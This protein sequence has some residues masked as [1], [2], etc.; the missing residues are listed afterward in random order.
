MAR[1]PMAAVVYV[2][3]VLL[4]RVGKIVSKGTAF[5]LAFLTAEE[6]DVEAMVAVVN[7]QVVNPVRGVCGREDHFTFVAIPGVKGKRL[8]SPMDVV[9]AVLNLC[10]RGC[11]WQGLPKL[12]VNQLLQNLPNIYEILPQ[13]YFFLLFYILTTFQIFASDAEVGP[14]PN[15]LSESFAVKPTKPR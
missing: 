7:V 14:K 3:F 13:T 2:P 4:V 8:D 10:S 11:Q 12:N 1:K 15:G 6:I 5:L 9:V